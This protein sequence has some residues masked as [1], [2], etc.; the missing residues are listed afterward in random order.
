MQKVVPD[1]FQYDLYL[2]NLD[3]STTK[4]QKLP[5]PTMSLCK[6][7]TAAPSK[8]SKSQTERAIKGSR[9]AARAPSSG[10]E[11]DKSVSGYDKIVGIENRARL[12]LLE[13]NWPMASRRISSNGARGVKQPIFCPTANQRWRPRCQPTRPGP[14][15]RVPV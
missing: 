4:A 5:N 13:L 1:S 8:P 15:L 12:T 10:P 6:K 11:S 3:E 2:T 7:P 14:Y 9:Q